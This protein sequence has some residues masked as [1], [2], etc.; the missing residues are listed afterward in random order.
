MNVTIRRASILVVVIGLYTFIALGVMMTQTPV[1]SKPATYPNERGFKNAI[2]WFELVDSPE[3][4]FLVLGDPATEIGKQLRAG[5][6]KLN[7]YDFGYMA[8]YAPFYASLF[9]FILVILGDRNGKYGKIVLYTGLALS[10]AMLVGDVC[11]NVVLFKLSAYQNIAEVNRSTVTMLQIF[12]RIKWFA[13]L[14]A[15]ILLAF[16]YLRYFFSRIAGAVYAILFLVPSIMGFWAFASPSKGNLLETGSVFI[17]LAQIAAFGHAVAKL[18][19][20][21]K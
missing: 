14:I 12:T 13:I 2:Y 5:M 17:G 7:R 15:G 9:L 4:L 19:R 8:G 1:K 11:E 18:F 6:D 10:A 3:E 20:R 16:R 21:V